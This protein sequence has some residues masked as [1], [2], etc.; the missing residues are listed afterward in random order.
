MTQQRWDELVDTAVGGPV[1]PGSM[2]GSTGLR[3]GSKFFAIWWHQQLVLKL[4][5]ERATALAAAGQATAFEPM[6]GRRMNGW[7]V[8][9]AS[10]DWTP[11]ATEACEFVQSLQA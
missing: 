7:V 6:A 9:A 5:G 2:F 10:A 3:T 1:T 4:P 11:L 8:V